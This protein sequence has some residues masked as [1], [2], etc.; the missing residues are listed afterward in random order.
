MQNKKY[1]YNTI[2]TRRESKVDIHSKEAPKENNNVSY[3]AKEVSS[4]DTAKSPEKK[5]EKPPNIVC[6][7][8]VLVFNNK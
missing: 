8:S 3:S 2:H 5:L 1:I 7:E 6:G 4:P